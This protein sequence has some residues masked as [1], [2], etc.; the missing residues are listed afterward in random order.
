MYVEFFFLFHR[1]RKVKLEIKIK[2]RRDGI[3]EPSRCCMAFRYI[4]NFTL[5]QGLCSQTIF[6]DI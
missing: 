3:R 2:K 1:K 5:S 4:Q 6:D